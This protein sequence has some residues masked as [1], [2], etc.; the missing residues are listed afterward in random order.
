MESNCVQS[1]RCSFHCTGLADFCPRLCHWWELSVIA[2]CIIVFMWSFTVET[3]NLWFCHF[4]ILLLQLKTVGAAQIA[5]QYCLMWRTLRPSAG[6]A[7]QWVS[8]WV[9]ECCCNVRPCTKKYGSAHVA[10]YIPQQSILCQ[11]CSLSHIKLLKLT[12]DSDWSSRWE[13]W[14]R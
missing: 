13:L 9:S 3:L 14:F 8:E 10:S 11:T 5:S 7:Q 4:L 1:V 2:I 12:W 6:Q